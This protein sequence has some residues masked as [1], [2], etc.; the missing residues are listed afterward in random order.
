MALAV[1]A[2]FQSS[3]RDAPDFHARTS[4]AASGPWAEPIPGS[5]PLPHA[6]ARAERPLGQPARPQSIEITR[7]GLHAPVVPVGVDKQGGAE[8]PADP[9]VAGWYRFGTAPGQ[10]SGSAVLIGHVDSRSGDLGEFAALRDVRA[11]D[12]V[13]VRRHGAPPVS[14]RIA[15]RVTVGKSDLPAS[16]FARTGPPVLRLITCATPY[17][18]DRGGYLRN[19]VVTAVPV[20]GTG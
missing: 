16:T 12:V 15:A 3:A 8:V 17:D 9:G 4:P 7:V 2:T 11:G 10:T 18:P 5:A 14:Y 13:L 6:P 1:G 19:L 20:P